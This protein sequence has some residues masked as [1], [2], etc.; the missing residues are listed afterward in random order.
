[1]YTA[2]YGGDVDLSATMT[3][4][5]AV[6]AFG[7]SRWI[8]TKPTNGHFVFVPVRNIPTVDLTYTTF[9]FRTSPC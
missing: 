2:M 4:S 9:V 7:Q 3:F 8:V 6:L 1:M 5:S